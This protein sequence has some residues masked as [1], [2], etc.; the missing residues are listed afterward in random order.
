MVDMVPMSGLVLGPLLRH[1]GTHGRD[2]L[3]RD[4][5]P[6]RRSRSSAAASGPGPSRATTTRWSCVE[7]LAPGT[8]TPYDVRLDGEVV[9]PPL[10]CDAPA[11]AHPHP[12]RRAARCGSRS[13]PAATPRR[14]RSTDDSNFDA[15]A[16]DA[17][18][19]RMIGHAR[20]GLAR[21]AGCCSATRSTP[22]R[23]PRRRSG[24][25]ARGATSPTR[26]ATR[27]ADFEEYT[28]LYHESWTDPD[29]RWL[30]STLPSSMIFDDH[31]VR[32]DWNTS[33]S[34]RQEMQAHVV[35]GGAH[36]RRP[37]VVLGL[38]APGQPL[39]G[40]AGRGRALPAG[41]GARRRRRA[42]AARVRRGRRRARPT[43]Q[44]GTRWS[45]RRDLG[46]RAAADDRLAVRAD[47]R[48]AATAHGL[49]RTS[50]PGSR[51]RSTATTT[52]C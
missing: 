5:Q 16:L 34:W 48:R 19:R 44:K 31:D 26:R 38:P 17:F 47:P 9:W 39:A 2:R 43:A 14:P 10:D 6:L 42:A 33:D 13:A 28:W 36:H 50:S 29:V 21:R 25:S 12:G 1:V 35:V 32:D 27:C 8:S 52:T 45:F 41:A 7:G 20:A 18:A 3:G 37:L 15:D 11:V 24:G 23:P 4:R 30:L 49:P 40:G 46:R 51:S 22:T